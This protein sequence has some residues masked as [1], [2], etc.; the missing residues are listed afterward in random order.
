MAGCITF[1]RLLRTYWLSVLLG[2]W[3]CMQLLDFQRPFSQLRCALK[4]NLCPLLES[5]CC[6]AVPFLE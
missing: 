6:K 4:A 3:M 2:I 1:Y 5:V